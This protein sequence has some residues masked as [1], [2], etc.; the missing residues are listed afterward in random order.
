M[1][2][3]V[4]RR[5]IVHEFEF[6]EGL[7]RFFGEVSRADKIFSDW[8]ETLA[9]NPGRGLAVRG[10]PEYLGLPI[11]TDQGSYLVIYWFD[12]RNVYCVGMRRVPSGVHRGP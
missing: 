1:S 2:T 9:R 6:D 8:L 11:H 5:S 7:Q 4:K 3:N 12:D 10:A